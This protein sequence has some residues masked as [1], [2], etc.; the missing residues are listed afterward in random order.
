VERLK[1]MDIVEE[2]SQSLLN[3]NSGQSLPAVLQRIVAQKSRELK[4]VVDINRALAGSSDR[5]ELFGRIAAEAKTILRL[6]GVILRL[7]RDDDPS[8]SNGK[9][10]SGKSPDGP[11]LSQ[12]VAS[13]DHPI[14]IKDIAHERALGP[15]CRELMTSLGWRSMLGAPL[16]AGEAAIGALV[17]CCREERDFQPDEIDF[18]AALADQAAIAAAASAARE[19]AARKSAEA[20]KLAADVEQ[21]HRAKAK[22]ISAVSHELRTPLQVIVGSADLLKD[23]VVEGAAEQERFL[24]SITQNA[25]ALDAMIGSMIAV[26][27]SDAKQTCLDISRVAVHE[28]MLSVLRYATRI[29]RNRRLEFS[30]D[31]AKGLPDIKT[32]ARKLEELLKHL[33]GNACK[34]TPEGHVGVR[35][36]NLV[37]RRRLE[38]TVADTGIGIAAEHVEKIFDEFFQAAPS[39]AVGL[40]LGLTIVKR[41]LQLMHGEISVASELG[42]GATFTFTLPHSI[43]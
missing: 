23:G 1:A 35:V 30:C 12:V 18:I 28:V 20:D 27:R 33:V 8:N 40:G 17:G 31:V 26:A 10:R 11:S 4:A 37:K 19:T 2:L 22:F 39:T 38:F 21:A 6:D 13:L 7:T 29:N 34:F 5:E 24:G 16:R 41:Y 25:E 43:D 3:L 42:R 36:R 14:A 32:D 15:A 9:R